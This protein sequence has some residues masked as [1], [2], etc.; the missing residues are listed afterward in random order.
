MSRCPHGFETSVVP[1]PMWCDDPTHS[2][3]PLPIELPSP[4]DEPRPVPSLAKL[5]GTTDDRRL[6]RKGLFKLA[7]KSAGSTPLRKF[8]TDDLAGEFRRARLRARLGKA[9]G[10]SLEFAE[11]LV[12]E[13]LDG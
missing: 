5:R 8:Y 6:A 10:I 7:R 13:E 11:R 12:S 2:A 9:L 1:C 4:E 3:P